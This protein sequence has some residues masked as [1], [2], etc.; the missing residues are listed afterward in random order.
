MLERGP[1]VLPSQTGQLDAAKR[2]LDGRHVVVIDPAGPRLERRD[3]AVRARQ[4]AGE[5]AGCQAKFRRV[6]A[7]DDLV[8]VVELEHRHDGTKDLFAYDGEVIV[9]AVKYGGR[10]EAAVGQIADRGTL[11]ADQQPRAFGRALLDV[12]K[13]LRQVLRQNKRANLGV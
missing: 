12:A 10:H 11:A 13:Y 7:R 6:R 1:A 2:Q 8:L 4:V 9:A 5:H 3:H